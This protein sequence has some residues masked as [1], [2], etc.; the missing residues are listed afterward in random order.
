MTADQFLSLVIYSPTQV[1][2]HQLRRFPVVDNDNK[3]VEMI[4]QVDVAIRV[5]QPE[6]TSEMVKEISKNEFLTK[7]GPGG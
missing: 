1:V 3:I 2:E 7:D 6:K 4:A 5:D